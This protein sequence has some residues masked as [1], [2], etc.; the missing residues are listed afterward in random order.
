M[1]L[2][3][4]AGTPLSRPLPV[5]AVAANRNSSFHPFEQVD[6]FVELGPLFGD[7]ARGDRLRYAAGGV[8]LEDFALSLGQRRFDRLHLMQDVDA[9]A[10]VAYH[11][12]H[13]AHLSFDPAQ[14]IEDGGFVL[15]HD[16]AVLWACNTIG[17]YTI[18]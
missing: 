2:R 18:C 6:E 4:F 16:H 17:G 11:L 13:A 8:I 12:R 5:H 14:P 15:G 1:A 7:I 3:C 9:V 10:V